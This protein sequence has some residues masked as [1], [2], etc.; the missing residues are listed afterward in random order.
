M[1]ARNHDK[2][3]LLYEIL[4]EAPE[5]FRGH[6]QTDA[7][8]LMNVTFR[9]PSEDLEGRFIAEAA[10][11]GLVELKGHRSVGGIRASIYNAMPRE[12]VEALAA[13][14]REFYERNEGSRGEGAT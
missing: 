8:S 14:M 7:R 2:A 11:Q 13:F 10:E 1:H 12:G 5:L 9:L 4:D 6:A 3:N